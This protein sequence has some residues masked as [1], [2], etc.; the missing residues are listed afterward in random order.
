MDATVALRGGGPHRT[1]PLRSRDRRRRPHRVA[2]PDHAILVAS[3][4][5][6]CQPIGLRRPARR[7][8]HVR[9]R[10]SPTP[11]TGCRRS[12]WSSGDAGIG[13]TT[14]VS[15]SAVAGRRRPVPRAV[16]A[17]RR[18]HHSVGAAR[19]SA[20]PGPPVETGSADR[21]T[22]A[23]GA[24]ALVRTRRGRARAARMRRMAGC[25]SPSSS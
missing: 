13:K 17:H 9:T 25:S 6:A 22:G 21:G 1:H 8:G 19:R 18:R 24:A 5:T 15:E 2:L 23:G 16:H 7:A 4:T 20:A 11:A 10:A 12:C 3:S 14:I